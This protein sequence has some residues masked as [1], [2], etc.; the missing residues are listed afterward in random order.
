[1]QLLRVD[2]SSEIGFGHLKRASLFSEKLKM[3]NEKVIIICKECEQRYTDIPII[4]IKNEDGFFEKVK[5]LKPDKVIIDNYNFTYED[6][7]KF[8]KLFPYIKLICF[9][10]TYEKHCCD[11]II[12]HN[13][14]VN[15][16][17][18]DNPQKVKI[19]KPLVGENFK[20]AKKRRYKKKGIFISFGGTD[21]KGIG[22]K[23]LRQLKNC[24]LRVDF[25]TTSANKNLDKLKKFCFLNRWC[26]LHIDED[27][28][29]GMAKSEFGVITPSTV[30]YEAIYMGLDFI[31]VEVAENQKEIS[32]YLKQKR[33][34]VLNVRDIRKIDGFIFNKQ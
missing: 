24:G 29:E 31:A 32:K 8:K 22:L 7:K 20:K 5:E 23:V 21:A 17:K 2:F 1:L 26:R 14:G 34:K 33:I 11:E 18:Y 25:Y 13:L 4:K 15:I 28:A 19:I 3:K 12:N 6:E 30:A 27:V 9:D 16:N 10:D